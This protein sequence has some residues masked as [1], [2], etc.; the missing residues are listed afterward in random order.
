MAG[1][2]IKRIDRAIAEGRQFVRKDEIEEWGGK[3]SGPDLEKKL[4]ESLRAFAE[5]GARLLEDGVPPK[6]EPDPK[7]VKFCPE[8]AERGLL[9][10]R[11]CLESNLESARKILDH[12][13]W[14]LTPVE[15]ED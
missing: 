5:V 12:I 2:P 6:E 8:L 11:G 10:Q 7:L 4:R 13:I 1:D 14:Q 3:A 15:E 9:T